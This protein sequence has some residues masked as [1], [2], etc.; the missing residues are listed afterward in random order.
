MT[1]VLI[2]GASGFLGQAVVAQCQA[3]GGDVRATARR[4]PAGVRSVEFVAHDLR[5]EDGLDDLVESVDTVV[6]AAGLSHRF[7]AA[8]E[9]E[10]AFRQSNALATERLARASARAGISHF[11]FVSSVSVHGNAA[12]A[13]HGK[14]LPGT[15]L[16]PYAR[17]KAEA[18]RAVKAVAEASGMRLTI[19]RFATIYGERDPGNVMRLIRAIDRNRFIFV[20]DGANVKSLIHVDDAA[21]ACLA[22][23]RQGKPEPPICTYDVSATVCPVEEIVKHIRSSLGK[24][25]NSLRCPAGIALAAATGFAKLTGGWEPARRLER[26]L[27]TWRR[28]DAFPG[29]AFQRALNFRPAVTL[30]AGISRQVHWY[31]QAR[32]PCAKGLREDASARYSA[33]SRVS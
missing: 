29:E 8:A 3:D 9:E 26:S 10:D 32:M 21:R 5:D 19:L 17:S 4:R 13:S 33:C 30:D 1:R 27:H 23:V 12:A 15:T 28:N 20:G 31:L 25:W 2:T 14:G 7:G 18:E 24:R 22:T 11:I 16:S 6:H